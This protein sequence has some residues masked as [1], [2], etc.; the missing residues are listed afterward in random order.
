[1]LNKRSILTLFLFII[2]G[3]LTAEQC[4]QEAEMC[5]APEPSSAEDHEKTKY[6]KGYF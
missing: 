2:I 6:Q 1:M 3:K 5:T 4:S